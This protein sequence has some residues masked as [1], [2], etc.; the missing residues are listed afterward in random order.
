M[1]ILRAAWVLP[2][3]Q[4]PIRNGWVAIADRRIVGVGSGDPD[5][6]DLG[7]GDLAGSPAPGSSARVADL[8]RVAL[9]PGLVNAHTHL[10]LS[11][12]R[13]RVPPAARFTSWVK[14][15][16]A[17]RGRPAERA[18]DPRVAGA[19][20][21][22]AREASETGTVAVGDVGNSLASVAAIAAEGLSGTVFHELV[23]FRETTDRIV[24]QT[25]PARA[26]ARALDPRVRVS[27]APHAPYSVS[28]ELFRA[29]RA[30]VA[31]SDHPVSTVH[32]AESP[33]EMELLH[34]GTGEWVEMLCWIGAWRDDWTPPRTGPVEYLDSL[35]VIDERTLVVHAVQLSDASLSRLAHRGAT[36]VT[37][38]RSN[39]WVG[40]GVPPLE[41]FYLSGV[42]VAVGTDSLASVAD[43]NLFSELAAMRW[44]APGV[45]A[46][47]LIESATLIGA[48]A[49]GLE[50]GLGSLTPGKEAW[51][52][53]VAVPE[54]VEHVEEYL[55][56]GIP[57]ADISWAARG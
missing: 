43:L 38:P 50:A 39:Q 32:V 36:L 12:L 15:M 17:V 47:R 21:D 10:E 2:V 54:R 23:G 27:V 1:T 3:D 30:E 40:V 8:G 31:A 20:R 42:P 28:P 7:R 35:G 18:D 5:T 51:V 55:V 4:P 34:E 53:S 25:R 19:A 24:E 33:E 49:L 45:S 11:W 16:F 56:S 41:R 46:R 13:G 48:R 29:I 6:R 37:C 52:V 26:A 14:T 57:P 9:L 44:I 22:A